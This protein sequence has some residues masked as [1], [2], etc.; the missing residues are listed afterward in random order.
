MDETPM[1]TTESTVLGG[2]WIWEKKGLGWT[3]T[4]WKWWM[5]ICL[6]GHSF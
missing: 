2:S 4:N 5:H 6:I 1:Y 3:R